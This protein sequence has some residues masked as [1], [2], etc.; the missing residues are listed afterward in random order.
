[1]D[2]QNSNTGRLQLQQLQMPAYS[3]TDWLAVFIRLR[4]TYNMKQV[5]KDNG[6]RLP[7]S[8]EYL[9]MLAAFTT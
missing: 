2:S 5:F 1:M 7:E 9:S 3:L 4:K 8:H 6:G